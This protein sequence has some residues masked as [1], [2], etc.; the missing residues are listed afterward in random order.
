MVLMVTNYWHGIIH[1]ATCI[2]AEVH[3]RGIKLPPADG[4]ST[5]APDTF[6]LMIVPLVPVQIGARYLKGQ[7]CGV[8]CASKLTALTGTGTIPATFAGMYL[9]DMD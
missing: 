8:F 3:G 4:E 5:C 2:S 7:H 1:C 9:L 6:G